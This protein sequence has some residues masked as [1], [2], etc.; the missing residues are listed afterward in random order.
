MAWCNFESQSSFCIILGPIQIL[1]CFFAQRRI[2]SNL[3]TIIL[4]NGAK[5]DLPWLFM[6]LN[7]SKMSSQFARISVEFRGRPVISREKQTLRFVRHINLAFKRIRCGG[8]GG[9]NSG[10]A[11]SSPGHTS[12][13]LFLSRLDKSYHAFGINLNFNRS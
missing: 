11:V 10:W 3:T 13:I 8:L 5:C 4:L 9:R 7:R 12:S 2:N 6:S 1:P